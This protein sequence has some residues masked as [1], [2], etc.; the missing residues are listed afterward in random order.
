MTEQEIQEPEDL[1][2][3]I[4]TKEEVFWTD[5]KRKA[6]QDNF[7]MAMSIL[8]NEQ[9]IKFADERIAEEQEKLKS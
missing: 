4:G 6:E 1:G 7:N 9:A 3:K 2:V 5:V 8:L